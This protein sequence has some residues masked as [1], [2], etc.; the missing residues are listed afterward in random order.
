MTFVWCHDSSYDIPTS[1]RLFGLISNLLQQSVP[2]DPDTPKFCIDVNV[3]FRS[4]KNDPKPKYVN[5]GKTQYGSNGTYWIRTDATLSQ[6]R[7]L[8][9]NG[10]AIRYGTKLLGTR[11]KTNFVDTNFFFIDIDKTTDP[12]AIDKSIQKYATSAFLIYKTPSYTPENPR[13][14][15][16]FRLSER[17]DTWQD[18]K[19]LLQTLIRRETNEVFSPDS[20][21]VDPC[22]FSYGALS[23]DAVV[24]YN[25]QNTFDLS[26]L[27][28]TPDYESF[29]NA[30]TNQRTDSITSNDKYHSRLIRCLR[31]VF[32]N[33]INAFL[34]SLGLEYD[35]S[36][37]SV[38]PDFEGLKWEGKNPFSQTN[39]SGK[40]LVCSLKDG[41]IIFY[42][43]SSESDGA[44]IFGFYNCVKNDL[45]VLEDTLEWDEFQDLYNNFLAQLLINPVDSNELYYVDEKNK[46]RQK[47]ITFILDTYIYPKMRGLCYRCE[48]ISNNQIMGYLYF[49]YSSSGKI[50][51][52][53]TENINDFRHQVIEVFKSVFDNTP[54]WIYRKLTESVLSNLP[55]YLIK[56]DLPSPDLNYL[57]FSNGLYNLHT[58][59]LKSFTPKVWFFVDEILPYPYKPSTGIG[60]KTLIQAL[61]QSEVSTEDKQIILNSYLLVMHRSYYRVSKYLYFYGDTSTGKTSIAKVF[62]YSLKCPIH[63]TNEVTF[64]P[65]HLG[66]ILNE[67]TVLDEVKSLHKI[68]GQLSTY[69]RDF[70]LGKG[71]TFT[72][73]DKYVKSRKETR[74]ITFIMTGEDLIF[75]TSYN[76]TPDGS[77]QRL[78]AVQFNKPV[79]DR[80]APLYEISEANS[81]L[82]HDL[83]CWAVE[84]PTDRT[85]KR[86]D[87]LKHLIRDSKSK[88]AERVNDA[89]ASGDPFIDFIS[90]FQVDPLW[91]GDHKKDGITSYSQLELVSAYQ[92]ITGDTTYKT[93]SDRNRFMQQFGRKIRKHF[94]L[95]EG[96]RVSKNNG[97][98]YRYFGIKFTDET[99]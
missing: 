59:E 22:R 3:E 1:L 14:R 68:A 8:I 99:K 23:S 12:D 27:R 20:S 54:E 6:I 10:F 43:R 61:K 11:Y 53:K 26:T 19:A 88:Q 67:V 29:Y 28:S 75:S 48:N 47:D 93:S 18:T 85:Q 42:D 79:F 50:G 24:F 16:V 96:R 41:R 21:C 90:T 40:S 65:K 92:A 25:E 44:S 94:P 46:K 33:D 52:R 70:T 78:I 55:D 77:A 4:T 83:A 98:S 82:L 84:Q 51:W 62:A 2:T 39:A 87:W 64:E 9:Q 91:D 95:Y 15:I 63:N 32:N 76:G 38:S 58:K 13:H 57:P 60:Y 72:Y 17:L 45:P 49:L 66:A 37:E 5:A 74:P 86:I 34:L 7:A 31:E 97:E 30:L 71:N 80:E 56:S 81:P 89:M 73:C 36:F 69:V 35:F